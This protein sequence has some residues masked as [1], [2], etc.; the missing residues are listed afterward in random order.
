MHDAARLLLVCRHT[1]RSSTSPMALGNM[2]A[3]GVRSLIV[4]CV[5]CHRD[6]VFNDYS[7]CDEV[8]AVVLAAQCAQR[9]GRS[10]RTRDRIGASIVHRELDFAPLCARARGTMKAPKKT[11]QNYDWHI[12]RI[13]VTSSAS[14]RMPVIMG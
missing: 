13:P 2:R 7:Y 6:M 10:V 14:S 4:Y 3:N 1:T 11:H 9:A 5:A 8:V 12:Y